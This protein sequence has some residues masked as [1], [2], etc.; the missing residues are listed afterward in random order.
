VEILDI[1]RAVIEIIMFTGICF[2]SVYFVVYL[3]KFNSAI[4]SIT[5]KIGNI[6]NDVKPV[7]NDISILTTKLNIISEKVH[8][9]S[10]NVEIVSGKVVKKSEEVEHYIDNARDSIGAKV[11]SIMN[12]V[13]TLN[14]GFKTFYKKIN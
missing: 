8:A 3:K 10:G 6:E 14:S 4:E 7:L 13:H 5:A 12:V 11:R 9:I 1:I 2:A